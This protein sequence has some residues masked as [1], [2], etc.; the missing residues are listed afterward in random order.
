MNNI[1][2]DG[3]IF[4]PNKIYSAVDRGAVSEFFNISIYTIHM[5]K[6]L[7]KILYN[8]SDLDIELFDLL[9]YVFENN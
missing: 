2:D 7:P 8:I 1:L 3:Q 5:P 4:G 6:I 9:E